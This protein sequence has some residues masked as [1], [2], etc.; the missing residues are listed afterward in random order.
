MIDN[1]YERNTGMGSAFETIDTEGTTPCA[2]ENEKVRERAHCSSM[3]AG[4]REHKQETT[5]G[6]G[7]KGHTVGEQEEVETEREYTM[8]IGGETD[9]IP[10]E[11]IAGDS[12]DKSAREGK[13][14][15][16]TAKNGD[17]MN[18]NDGYILV[19]EVIVITEE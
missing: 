5:Q 18:D 19:D 13:C 11:R 2:S 7:C 4:K 12:D 6:C 15:K 16:S 3:G 17:R 10:T 1:M 9:L 8:S 14:D